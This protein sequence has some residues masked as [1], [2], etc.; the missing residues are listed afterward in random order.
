MS[1]KEIKRSALLLLLLVSFPLRSPAQENLNL[2]TSADISYKVTKKLQLS[3]EE[4][5]RLRDNIS[6]TDRVQSTLGANYK[7]FKWL[8]AGAGYTLI[9]YNH[10]TK[11]WEIRHRFTFDI[12]GSYKINKL[13]ISLREMLQN[14]YR[15]GVNANDTR[16]NPKLYLRSR[17]MGSLNL[18]KAGFSP[19]ISSEF[20]NT[21]NNPQNNEL[22]KIRYTFGTKYK[23]NSRNSV[24]L[25]Y[26]YVT[27][28]DDDDIE[29]SNIIGIGYSFDIK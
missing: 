23:I 27:E 3:L 18:K 4:E 10:P 12:E 22:V 11:D 14:T 17:I 7:I 6:T 25:F 24:N 8:K 1:I 9:N 28:K 26:R 21:L 13:E 2:W 5:F 16:A 20:Y 19:Y 15:V 29:G